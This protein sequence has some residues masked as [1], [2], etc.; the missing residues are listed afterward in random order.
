[1]ER[2][3]IDPQREPSN[4]TRCITGMIPNRAG[5]MNRFMEF[6]RPDE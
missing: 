1:M 4:T 2:G 5:E 3:A 6:R